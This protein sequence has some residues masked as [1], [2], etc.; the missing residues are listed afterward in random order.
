MKKISL[1]LIIF[2][3]LFLISPVLAQ[4]TTTASPSGT[5]L[6]NLDEIKKIREAVQQKVT[7][8]LNEITT[9]KDQKRGWYGT[10]DKIEDN[11]INI[12]YQEN[13][14]IVTFDPETTF[15]NE[16]KQKTDFSK[17]KAGQNI[18][19]MGQI[20]AD[21]SLEAVRVLVVTPG[22]INKRI[23]TIGKIADISK[24]SP[25]FVVIPTNNK[26]IQ[27]QV[28]TDNSTQVINKSATKLEVKNLVAGQRIVTILK[29]DPKNLKS[30]TAQKIIVLDA[31][32]ENTPTPKK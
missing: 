21:G 20:S 8:K 18:I 28:K 32:S 15:I 9:P 7:E 29:Q 2:S 27:Y 17:I 16:K 31:T 25:I 26:N 11:K 5:I 22:F 3:S 30:Y 12:S 24:S 1:V 4:T 23:I 14:R 13:S 19:A 10:I 6:G